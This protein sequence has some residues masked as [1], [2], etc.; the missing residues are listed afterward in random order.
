MTSSPGQNEGPPAE[1]SPRGGSAPG[2]PA[3]STDR[4]G[5]NR[6]ETAATAPRQDPTSAKAGAKKDSGAKGASSKPKARKPGEDWSVFRT[7]VVLVGLV[8]AG[9]GAYYLITGTAGLPETGDGAVNPTL[10]NQFRFFAAMMI[11]V[12]AAFVTIAIKFQWSNML[13]LV[14]LM[15]FIGGIG[16]VLSWAFSGTPHF[17]MIILMIVELAFPAALLVWHKYIAKTSEMRREY[18]E[19]S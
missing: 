6:T 9:F 14:C 8:I 11:G 4:R 2:T 3:G 18:S 16:R 12:G 17:L 5:D 7:V 19:R 10:E 1:R 15:V 13:W